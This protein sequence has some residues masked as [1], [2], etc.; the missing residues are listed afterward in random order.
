M[1]S[2]CNGPS[3]H[4][5]L[6]MKYI[7]EVCVNEENC[8]PSSCD[9]G[10]FPLESNGYSKVSASNKDFFEDNHCKLKKPAFWD[11]W[12]LHH[13]KLSTSDE[14]FYYIDPDNDALINILE[15]YSNGPIPEGSTDGGVAHSMATIGSNPLNPD[16]D[17]DLLLDGFEAFFGL[18]PAEVDDSTADADNDGL[19]NLQEQIF[20]CDPLNG[21]SDGD[22][23]TDGTEVEK[24]GNPTDRND[25]GSRSA[26][27]KDFAMIKLTIGDPSGSHSE[28]YNLHVGTISHQAPDFGV[29]GSGT[30]KFGP[31]RY[32]I[33][34][35]W[36]ATNLA[37]PDY[38]YEADVTKVSGN[39][40]VTV[41]DPDDILG[42]FH[43][44]S[45]FD[46]T[47]GKEA[48]LIVEGECSDDA[49]DETYCIDTCEECQSS[50]FRIW[51]TFLDRC[52]Q[53]IGFNVPDSDCPCKKCEK[54]YQQ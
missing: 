36:V 13:F 48:T 14:E 37:T 44:S 3:A 51:N 18:S 12:V 34:V 33:I 2:N 35:R 43:D 21:D 25:D 24:Q 19:T 17:G 10:F 9:F 7:S 45:D 11:E 16:S 52:E 42:Q 32:T 15:Y 1:L 47:V 46:R 53:F 39:A 38:D 28:R 26:T 8:I 31:G 30:Y 29:V 40:T 20:G 54:W 41:E 27:F 5:R 4:V 49:S 6:P 23:V 50:P 22:G